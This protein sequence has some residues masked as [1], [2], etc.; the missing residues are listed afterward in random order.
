MNF[1]TK[2]K[3][4]PW[5]INDIYGRIGYKCWAYE[6]AGSGL[7]GLYVWGHNPH[8]ESG[9]CRSGSDSHV[10]VLVGSVDCWKT[11][12]DDMVGCYYVIA[13][14]TDGTA[15]AWGLNNHGQLGNG[16]YTSASSPSQIAGCWRS[17][18]A[19]WY[20]SIGVKCDGTLWTWGANPHGQLGL[21]CDG[22]SFP[23]PQQV[24]TC[25]DWLCGHAGHHQHFAIKCDNT[26]WSWGHNP[27]G[28]MGDGTATPR[29]SPV[30]VP[31][32]WTCARGN[33]PVIAR[34]TDG[35]MYVWG[36]N[37]HGQMGISNYSNYCSPMLLPGSWC[38]ISRPG[39]SSSSGNNIGV[40]SDCTLWVWGYLNHGDTGCCTCF[41][42]GMSSPYQV[43][44]SNWC[45]AGKGQHQSWGIKA[46]GTLWGWGANPHSTIDNTSL[47]R[48]SPQQILGTNWK[49]VAGGHWLVVG[50]TD[51][52]S[53]NQ[54]GINFE[55]YPSVFYQSFCCY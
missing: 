18:A 42:S 11:P 20:S 32:S 36:H 25:T 38:H 35:S 29:S 27:H 43:P 13:A 39:G 6:A 1:L 21:M 34:R 44:G 16:S 52:I 26:L 55:K 22:G 23:N 33:Y 7:Y 45:W 24:G 47:H 30:Q 8:G 5:T 37:P 53:T 50:R 51:G 10:P 40:K 41:N 17:V 9:Y 14:K 4:G 15:W 54:E 31:G 49:D 28:E 12:A 3:K 19:G 46:D 48:C 2:H